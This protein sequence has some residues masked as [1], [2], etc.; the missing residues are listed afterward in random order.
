[1]A[2]HLERTT[3]RPVRGAHRTWILAPLAAATLAL[4]GCG[5][6]SSDSSAPS[7]TSAAATTSV[8]PRSS[9]A[10]APTS[11]RR[12]RRGRGESWCTPR[13]GP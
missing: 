2:D 5:D 4:S 12:R 11:R 9:P 7:T 6:N 10:A 1:M 3:R 8:G 13:T